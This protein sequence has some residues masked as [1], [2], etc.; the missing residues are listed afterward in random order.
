MAGR[1]AVRREDV[2]TILIEHFDYEVEVWSADAITLTKDVARGLVWPIQIPAGPDR[3]P[4][5]VVEYALR[6]A[7]FTIEE[8][9]RALEEYLR[10]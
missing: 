5:E 6:N 1:R 4:L 2:L 9:W 10:R 7:D 8:F 3:L